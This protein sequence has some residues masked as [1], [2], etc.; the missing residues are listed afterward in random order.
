[1]WFTQGNPSGVGHVG[2]GGLLT[3]FRLPAEPRKPISIA[4]G[5]DGN[6]WFTDRWGAIWRAT[7]DGRLTEFPVQGPINYEPN[8]IAAGPDGALWFTARGF[9]G[10]LTTD[11]QERRFPVPSGSGNLRQITAGPVAASGSP[12][13]AAAA[14]TGS[15]GRGSAASPPAA[16]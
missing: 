15:G 14:P 8:G 6:V 7:P 10:R 16:R 9:I 1:M 5:P 3:E 2:P 13:R 4:L 11:G 12:I